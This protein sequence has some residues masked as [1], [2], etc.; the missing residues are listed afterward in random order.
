M[1]FITIKL[2]R[3]L[4]PSSFLAGV[5]WR[6]TATGIPTADLCVA[7]SPRRHCSPPARG[8]KQTIKTRNTDNELL[9]YYIIYSFDDATFTENYRSPAASR[10]GNASWSAGRAGIQIQSNPPALRPFRKAFCFQH[11]RQYSR[12]LFHGYNVESVAH[13]KL[14]PFWKRALSKLRLSF[15]A[16]MHS[17]RR[18]QVQP[19]DR[20]SWC[21]DNAGSCGTLAEPAIWKISILFLKMQ[22]SNGSQIPQC[23]NCTK[24]YNGTSCLDCRKHQI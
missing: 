13:C 21:G 20:S 17:I 15:N 9:L 23:V 11:L 1:D 19:F 10:S 7:T 12:L 14:S 22:L 24:H 8:R 2:S 6:R 18:H 5:I 16:T 4:S 3:Y